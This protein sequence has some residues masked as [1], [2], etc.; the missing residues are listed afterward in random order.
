[1][2][3]IA[4]SE[5]PIASL[6]SRPFDLV[7]LMSA[8]RVLRF[9]PANGPAQEFEPDDDLAFFE[10]ENCF[11]FP[12][13]A[14][15][16]GLAMHPNTIAAS[17]KSLARKP[18]DYEHRKHIHDAKLQS[19]HYLGAIEAV[20]FPNAP[21]TDGWKIT[22]RPTPRI[23]GVASIWKKSLGVQRIM[24]E[25]LTGRHQWSVSF[26]ASWGGGSDEPN[27]GTARTSSFAV[28]LAS[29]QKP[30]FDYSPKDFLES[31]WELVPGDKAPQS[32]IDTYNTK[33]RPMRVDKDWKGR[34]VVV[35]MNH[36][37]GR[38]NYAG[39]GLVRYGAEPAAR[40]NTVVASGTD[41]IAAGLDEMRVIIGQLMLPKI[42][43]LKSTQS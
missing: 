3:A 10:F 37:V 5:N 25:H 1:M 31:G 6:D 17:W 12:E 41:P 11:G 35:L 13:G 28:A 38:V 29:G 27:H 40:I 16:W 24:G 18:L 21:S 26:D 2:N 20:S 32:L 15:Q 19:D 4:Y 30:E 9:Q 33:A 22:D 14:T 39:L 23:H 36:Q 34:K 8:S 7:A 43:K 42:V